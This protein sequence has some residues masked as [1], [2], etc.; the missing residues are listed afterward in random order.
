M[1]KSGDR[2]AASSPAFTFRGERRSYHAC[3]LVSCAQPT[4]HPPRLLAPF[5]FSLCAARLPAASI[6]GVVTDATGAKV[7]G[8][9][10]SLVCNGQVVGSAV[11][12]ADGSFQI[13]TGAA[14]A[15][16]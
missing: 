6:H 10:V 5:C 11:S 3:F 1:R 16:F 8:A 7:T 4:P 15:S 9:S 13:T 2:S 14:A 12:T